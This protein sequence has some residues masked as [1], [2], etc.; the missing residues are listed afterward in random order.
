M[1][2]GVD[3][4][5]LTA[6]VAIA[7]SAALW[8]VRL[9]TGAGRFPGPDPV[10]IA[11]Q[12]EVPV[13]QE[14]DPSWT[15]TTT[16]PLAERDPISSP[17]SPAIQ[18]IDPSTGGL[19]GVIEATRVDQLDGMIANARAAHSDWRETSFET[20]RLVLRVLAEFILT[21]QDSIAHASMRDTG[22]T[23][24]DAFFGEVLTTLEKIRWLCSREAERA[25]QPEYRSVGLLTVHKR[26]RVE[27]VPRGVVAVIVSWNYPFHNIMG[28]IVASLFAG[29]AIVVKCS[30]YVA[31]STVNYYARIIHAVLD[32][33]GVSRDLVQFVVGGALVGD[34]LVRSRGLDKVTFI[35]SPAVGKLVMR[36][37]ADN[38]TPVTLELGGKDAAVVCD[39]VQ[40]DGVIPLIMRGCFQNMGQNCVGLERIVIH[41]SIHQRF[42]DAVVPMVERL[43]VDSP[44]ADVDGGAVTMAKHLLHIQSLID[45]A[46]AKGARVL[47]GGKSVAGSHGGQFFQPTVLD[48]VTHDM[49]IAQEEV[50]GPVMTVMQFSTDAEA[51]DIVNSSGYGLGGSVFSND[52]RR[53][54]RIMGRLEVGMCNVNDFG[55]NYLCQSLPFGGVKLSGFGR[56]AGVEG[57]R[58]ECTLKSITTDRFSFVKTTIPTPLQYPLDKTSEEFCRGMGR[59]AYSERYSDKAKG[60]VKLIKAL[61][62]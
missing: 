45:D 35:G 46:V 27:Y 58:G 36:A 50:F 43:R 54:E 24:V 30:E 57:L 15:A 62:A 39:D 13:P 21:H 29:N 34:A 11:R 52:I 53:A 42:I 7:I 59:M 8:Y 26:A 60:L 51:V 61:V 28:P 56:F 22:K 18:C 32:V 49:L 23:Y 10:N 4:R 47:C 1:L 55:V 41:S 16:V 44:F 14:A 33:A 12:I 37:A 31:W 17:S 20:R 5:V 9:S 3:P 40:L 25:L 19:L 6:A 48:W 38:L 2:D